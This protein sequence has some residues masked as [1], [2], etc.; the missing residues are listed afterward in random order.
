MSEDISAMVKEQIRDWFSREGI[1]VDSISNERAE[2]VFKVKF[3][4]FVFTV[5][6]PNDR[7]YVQI[8]SQILISQQHLQK[9]TTEKMQ[10]FQIRAM[11][12]GWGQ[13]VS[14]GFIRPQPGKP[15]PQP[16]GPGFVVSDRIYDDDY[17]D[18]KLWR[19]I[20]RLHST[21]DMSIS[22]LNEVTGFVSG[23]EEPPSDTGPSYYT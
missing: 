9:L 3:Q 17:T 14:M 15:G 7:N 2:F 5:V 11:Q 21:V 13:D 20:R 8:E 16:P 23:R 12:F 19:T 6:R 18:D 1:K 4:R 10:E 22:I